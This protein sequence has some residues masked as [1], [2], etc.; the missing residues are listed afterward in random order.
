MWGGKPSMTRQGICLCDVLLTLALAY[1]WTLS[2]P[3]CMSIHSY[4]PLPPFLPLL[5]YFSIDSH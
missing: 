3:S 5:S 1:I 4:T 2:M